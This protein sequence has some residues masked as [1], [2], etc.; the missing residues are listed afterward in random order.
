MVA[1]ADSAMMAKVL[2]IVG[3]SVGSKGVLRSPEVSDYGKLLVA[4]CKTR[5]QALIFTES[6]DWAAIFPFSHFIESYHFDLSSISNSKSEGKTTPAPEL[7]VLNSSYN[8]TT[9][10]RTLTLHAYHPH[11][12]WTVIIFHAHVTQWS[13]SDA[14]PDIAKPAT[15]VIRNAGGYVTTGWNITMTVVGEDSIPIELTGLERDSLHTLGRWD[16]S[17]KRVGRSWIWSDS[18][19]S[20]RVLRDVEKVV[21]AWV[22]GAYISVDVVKVDV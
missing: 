11:H 1:H 21:P 4:P 9:N 20:A 22:S 19:R 10:S 3:D 7:R 2:D 16:G 13:L 5:K 14:L 12:V 8:S 18:Y 6:I 17:H 15:Y